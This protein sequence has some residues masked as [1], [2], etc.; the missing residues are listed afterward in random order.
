MQELKEALKVACRKLFDLEVDAELTRPEEQFGDYATNVALQ[1]ASKLGKP[2]REIAESLSNDVRKLPIIAE[3]T[4]DGPGFIN[5]RLTDDFF[6][7]LT[8]KISENFGKNQLMTGKVV[9]LEH[10][11]PNPFKEFHI[12]HAYSNTVGVAIG[13][14][15]ANAGA[16][17]HQVS[18]HGDIGLHIAMAVYMIKKSSQT[19]ASINL[20]EAYAHGFQIYEND[21]AAKA[22]IDEINK[23][24]YS[25]QDPDI[26]RLYEESRQQSL[27]TFEKIYQQLGVAFE[28]QY[29]ESE[30][31]AGG[32]E[33]VRKNISRVFKQSDGAIVYDGEKAG[34]HMR[35]FITRQGLP[36]YESKEIGLAF[37][38][39]HDYPEAESFIVITANEID[40]YFR[41]L[42]AAIKEVDSS[43][44]NKIRHLSHGVVK[45]PGGKMSSRTGNVVQLSVLQADLESKIKAA[46]GDAKAT[47]EIV[48]GA[49]KYEFLK[50]RLGGDITFDID[51]SISLHGNS[52]PYLQYAHA[53][54][55]SILLKDDSP[56][57]QGG[58]LY[59]YNDF[60]A[61]ERSLARKISEYPEVVAK[62][63]AELMPHHVC[64]YLYELAQTFNSFYEKNR[65]IGDPRQALR[66]RLVKAYAQVLKN[67]LEL[68][69]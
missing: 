21:P 57:V 17:V 54:A 4:V 28:K 5:F 7:G 32:M 30:V 67:G 41:V 66:L 63:T 31:A 23:L 40:D 44:W 43:L 8:A 58:S 42:V 59:N 60:T 3:A 55:C 45:F 49:M 13:K 52:G 51:E 68:L 39:Q 6:N 61:G 19:G 26:N 14:L 1:L 53:R 29:F 62:A 25:R 22:E 15:L 12:G 2:P 47:S 34:L 64:N 33:I 9:V 69:N 10:T 48:L 56:D 16:L 18:Y 38:K 11:D 24:I 27:A 50:H 46:F 35:V 36:T 65:V 20:G 37:A